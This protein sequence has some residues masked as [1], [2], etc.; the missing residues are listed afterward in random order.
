M[1]IPSEAFKTFID[2]L[3]YR[4]YSYNRMMSPHIS[5]AQ[6]KAIYFNVDEMEEQ[7]QEFLKKG[8][9]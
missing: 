6:W 4:S 2:T 9:K 5:P 1:N 8:D 3:T 7:Y